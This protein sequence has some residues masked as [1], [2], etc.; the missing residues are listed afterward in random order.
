MTKRPRPGR[1]LAVLAAAL[2]AVWLA[3]TI[4]VNPNLHWDIV[5]KYQFDGVIL[6]GLGVTIQ[7]TL[8]SMILGIA[9]G[10]VV[11]V[12]QLSDSPVLRLTAGAYT[13]FFRGTP[14]LVQLIFWFNLAL[15]FPVI[16]IG[17]PFDGPKL[18]SW[19]SNQVITGFVAALLGLSINE[20][21]YMAEI[22]RG[23][24]FR[25][26]IPASARRAPP[27]G[28]RTAGSCP[29]SSFRRRCGSSF[30]RSAT[31]SSPCSRRPRWS[32]SSPEPI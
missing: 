4:I 10:I 12:M 32:R 2:F 3:Y 6:K 1:W 11:A 19:Q 20:G 9:I 24:R 8:I 7:L 26:W 22:V 30:R 5:A 14:L 13:W 18:I 21:A 25:A 31:S 15:L 23:L 16:S 27:S 28:C 29:G 17:I